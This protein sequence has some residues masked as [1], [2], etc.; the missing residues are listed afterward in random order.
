[1][2]IVDLNATIERNFAN[3]TVDFQKSTPGNRCNGR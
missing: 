2:F 1:M 3:L